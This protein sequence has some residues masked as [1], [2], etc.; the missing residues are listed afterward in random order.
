MPRAGSILRL[1]VLLAFSQQLAVS[2][3]P[4]G[5]QHS[6]SS[7]FGLTYGVDRQPQIAMMDPVTGNTSMAVAMPITGEISLGPSTFDAASQT[8]FCISMAPSGLPPPA[9][10][11]FMDLVAVELLNNAVRVTRLAGCHGILSMQYDAADGKLYAVVQ[12]FGDTWFASITESDGQVQRHAPITL[13][14]GTYRSVPGLSAYDLFSHTYYTMVEGYDGV[15][16]MVALKSRQVVA[17]G[18]MNPPR[19]SSGLGCSLISMK[20][21][22]ITGLLLA[23][24]TCEHGHALADWKPQL[25]RING[26]SGSLERR[27]AH[28][29]SAHHAVALYAAAFDTVAA[30]YTSLLEFPRG[31]T[32]SSHMMSLNVE[33]SSVVCDTAEEMDEIRLRCASGLIT[34]IDFAS[35]GAPEGEC[36]DFGVGWCHSK[37]SHEIMELACL[38][39]Q[40]CS[41][42]ADRLLF[43]DPCVTFAKR[44]CV[45]ATCSG[46]DGRTGMYQTVPVLSP[47]SRV[48]VLDLFVS[49][50]PY[51]SKI[52]PASSFVNAPTMLVRPTPLPR[53]TAAGDA[54]S[55]FSASTERTSSAWRPCSA[56]SAVCQPRRRSSGQRSCVSRPPAPRKKCRSSCGSRAAT[57]ISCPHGE[58]T[59]CPSTALQR[60][61]SRREPRR[62]GR[63][64]GGPVRTQRLR[65]PPHPHPVPPFSSPFI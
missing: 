49:D 51:I 62:W 9:P 12:H 52:V 15:Q 50:A 39:A 8:Y 28:N 24:G 37:I 57:A 42:V 10:E 11:D 60:S 58:P 44:L 61:S 16:R 32:H 34:S 2:T 17:N 4:W 36:G 47:D 63:L 45:Q 23:M 53:A 6:G 20:C 33:V 18:G 43:G 56:C 1:A 22:D 21:E 3:A 19:V 27:G 13:A 25:L 29:T 46:H 30:T 26:S 55:G 38:G 14:A 35:F 5:P 41:V 54:V 59:P 48:P 31:P 64:Q 65:L 7:L 40:S